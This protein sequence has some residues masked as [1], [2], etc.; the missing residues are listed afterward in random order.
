LMLLVAVARESD[1]PEPIRGL[2]AAGDE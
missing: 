1:R 2:Q